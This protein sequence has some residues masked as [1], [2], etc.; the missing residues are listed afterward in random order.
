[1]PKVACSYTPAYKSSV[2]RL[3]SPRAT[4]AVVKAPPPGHEYRQNLAKRYG[5]QDAG[6]VD[7][8]R[9]R[10]SMAGPSRKRKY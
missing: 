3:A 10:A 8:R 9:S 7:L 1:M 5:G 6:T 2:P 4:V